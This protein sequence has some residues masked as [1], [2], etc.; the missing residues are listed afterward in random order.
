MQWSMKH[1]I[2]LDCKK[3]K[4]LRMKMKIKQAK[5]DSVATYWRVCAASYLNSPPTG[6]NK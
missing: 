3:K 5:T 1:A 4:V 2:S 6:N